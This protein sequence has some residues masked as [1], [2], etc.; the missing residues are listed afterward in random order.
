MMRPAVANYVQQCKEVISREGAEAQRR[1]ISRGGAKAQ[2]SIFTQRRKGAE[3]YFHAKA[4]RRREVFSRGGAKAQ[5]S[6]FTRRRKGAEKFFSR[7]GAKAQR[8]R[9]LC[10]FAKAQLHYLRGEAL[11]CEARHTGPKQTQ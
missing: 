8:S 7:E 1:F 11:L 5:R 9:W 10:K 6:I 3:K 2:R 4:Q